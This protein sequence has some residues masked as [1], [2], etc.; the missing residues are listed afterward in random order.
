MKKNALV[1]LVT[2]YKIIQ[3]LTK[4]TVSS[5]SFSSEIDN[6]WFSKSCKGFLN[7]NVIS[8]CNDCIQLKKNITMLNHPELLKEINIP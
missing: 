6:N 7:K 3:S 8:Q 4:S 2:E 5:T 1:Q